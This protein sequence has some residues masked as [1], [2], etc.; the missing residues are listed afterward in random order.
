MKIRK[1]LCES[2]LAVT[3]VLA[4]VVPVSADTTYSSKTGVVDGYS[5]SLSIYGNTI[6]VN[7]STQ[8]SKGNCSRASNLKG[9]YISTAFTGT[10]TKSNNNGSGSGSVTATVSVSNT[11]TDRFTSATC[12][13]TFDG[14]SRTQTTS[15]Y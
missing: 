1:R 13:H 7:G 3:M 9:T 6:K 12:V 8:Y 11:S 5:Y 10:K 14:W 4:A 2:M 15:V